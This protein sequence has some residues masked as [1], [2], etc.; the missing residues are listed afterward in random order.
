MI[1]RFLFHPS[2]M[3]KKQIKSNISKI[4]K[5]QSNQTFIE[6]VRSGKQISFYFRCL[7][8]SRA[9]AQRETKHNQNSLHKRRKHSRAYRLRSRRPK[10][11]P[12]TR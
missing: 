8:T 3:S 6:A 4:L 10:N 12:V 11:V 7:R 5:I 1:V 9:N 2:I